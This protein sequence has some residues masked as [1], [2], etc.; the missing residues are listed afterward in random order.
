MQMVK[1]KLDEIYLKKRDGLIEI[2]MLLI[3]MEQIIMVLVMFLESVIPE[4]LL[5]HRKKKLFLQQ[6][7]LNLCH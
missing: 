5:H 7:P 3:G 4:I 1:N 2:S 6:I